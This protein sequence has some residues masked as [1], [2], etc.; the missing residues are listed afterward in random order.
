[1]MAV[2]KS[3]LGNSSPWVFSLLTYANCSDWESQELKAEKG[4]SEVYK[5]MAQQVRAIG[6]LRED[7]IHST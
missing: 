5:E 1:M 2:L 6:A 7:P 3:L 4:D